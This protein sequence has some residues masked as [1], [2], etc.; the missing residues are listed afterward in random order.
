MVKGHWK[1]L[2]TELWRYELATYLGESYNVNGTLLELCRKE[3]AKNRENLNKYCRLCVTFA[4]RNGTRTES[5]ISR[6]YRFK[7]QVDG[8]N[9]EVCLM[10]MM[11]KDGD[12]LLYDYIELYFDG[13]I[14]FDFHYNCNVA[15]NMFDEKGEYSPGEWERIVEKF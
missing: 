6:R 9:L 15:G 4:K 1:K 7:D 11:P 13:K 12:R 5:E 3:S 10:E 2:V 8:H 14:A